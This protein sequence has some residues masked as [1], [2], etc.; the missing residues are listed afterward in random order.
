[1]RMESLLSQDHLTLCWPRVSLNT[2]TENV[3]F[4]FAKHYEFYTHKVLGKCKPCLKV[5]VL[6][7]Y[8]KVR[9]PVNHCGAHKG[10]YKLGN[11]GGD[12]TPRFAQSTL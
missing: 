7:L 11:D 1:M 4:Y 12:V 8:V 6:N 3:L 10:E 2:H 5:V 9:E